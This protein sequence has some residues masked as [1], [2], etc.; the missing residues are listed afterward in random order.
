[1]RRH[2]EIY[3][4]GLSVERGNE[5]WRKE[6][7]EATSQFT[8]VAAKVGDSRPIDEDWQII[9]RRYHFALIGA[10]DSPTVLDFC[11][12]IY[13][14][15]DRYRRIAVPTQSFMA[16]PARD[17]QEI[18]EAAVAGQREK[19]QLLLRRHIADIAEVVLANFPAGPK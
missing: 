6:L 7:S 8:R 19:A 9:H 2:I 12:Q 16:G 15:F 1:V 11:K 13:D 3:A 14:R 5:Q 4:L 17:H 10:C 18:T